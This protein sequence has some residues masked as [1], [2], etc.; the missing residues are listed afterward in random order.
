[1][2]AAGCQQVSSGSQQVASGS[3]Q[4]AGSSQQTQVTP[5]AGGSKGGSTGSVKAK[6]GSCNPK[7]DKWCHSHPAIPGCTDSYMHSHA[8]TNP[9]HTH[10]YGCKGGKGKAKGGSG[11]KIKLPSVKAKGVYKGVV[12]MNAASREVMKQYQR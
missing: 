5:P 1:M 3:Q 4:V 9:K 12:S 2:F 8:Y 6:A 11:A 7:T 10:T